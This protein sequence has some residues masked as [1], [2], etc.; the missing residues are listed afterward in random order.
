MARKRNKGDID[1]GA[2]VKNMAPADLNQF[3]R[4]TINE[5]GLDA[6]LERLSAKQRKEVL[7]LLKADSIGRKTVATS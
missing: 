4:G 7:H 3:I 5:I 2:V 6:W 1:W